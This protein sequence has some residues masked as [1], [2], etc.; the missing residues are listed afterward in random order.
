MQ[1]HEKFKSCTTNCEVQVIDILNFLKF[2]L[3]ISNIELF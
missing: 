3:N 1:G 2:Y